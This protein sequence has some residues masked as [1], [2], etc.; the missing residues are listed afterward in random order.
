MGDSRDI[1]DH[2]AHL[3]HD[4]DR[5]RFFYFTDNAD[6]QVAHIFTTIGEVCFQKEHIQ[7]QGI[8][9]CQFDLAGKFDPG[10]RFVAINA[11]DNRDGAKFFS[12]LDQFQITVYLIRFY[13][14]AY[15]IG[16]FGIVRILH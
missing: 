7:L 11:C 9:S 10:I 15:V 12:L 5:N 13:I 16:R 1:A 3:D 8:G 4:R 2:F 14:P 6:I